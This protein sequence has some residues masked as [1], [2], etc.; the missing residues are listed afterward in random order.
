MKDAYFYPDTIE[1]C[2]K[3]ISNL[4]HTNESQATQLGNLKLLIEVKESECRA[5]KDHL[6]T[7][8]Q[9]NEALTKFNMVTYK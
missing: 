8:K 2:H 1:K 9:C 6:E 5:L 4:L 3:Q 7:M